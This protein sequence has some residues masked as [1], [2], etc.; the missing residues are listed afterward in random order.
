MISEDVISSFVPS[1]KN[2]IEERDK[3]IAKVRSQ[4]LLDTQEQWN[5]YMKDSQKIW[6]KYNLLL[7]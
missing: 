3:Q 7:P 5:I 6:D 2:L 1:T 4:Y